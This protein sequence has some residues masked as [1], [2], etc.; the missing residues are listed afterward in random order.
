MAAFNY[1]QLVRLVPARTWQFY[2]EAR[3]IDLPVDHDWAMPFEP[4]VKGLVVALEDLEA[5]LA[6]TIYA[7]LRRVHTLANRRG[8]L[9]LRNAARPEAALHE[10]FARLTSD[11]E[12]AL[13][14]MLQWPDLFDTAEA[15][16]SVD[17]QIGVRGWKRLK[18]SPCDQ[19]FR[20]PEEVNAL[21]LALASAF[22]PRKGTRRACEIVTLDRHL[23]GGVQFGILIEDNPQRKPEFADDDRVRWRDI[24]PPESMDVVIYP[25][26]GV[27]D[28]LAPG[29]ERTRKI[30]LA[31]FAQH[32]FKRSIQPQTIAQ[33]MFFL[34]RLR[35]GFE[36]FDD[37]EVDLAAHRVEHIR[38]SQARVRSKLT[39]SCD[40]IIKP[41]G[42][43]E[44]ADVLACVQSQGLEQPLMRSAFNIVD[45][46]VTLYFLPVGTKKRGRAAHIELKQ[47]GISNLRDLT[48]DEAKL[49]EALLQ[50]WG[51]MERSVGM[52][53][54][55]DAQAPAEVPH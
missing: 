25:A 32:V 11:A 34:N 16:L 51:V 2:F 47:G 31:H 38:L 53:D 23:D 24:R 33:P 40:Y 15:F 36:L 19:I 13:W 17:L 43:K 9:A 48:E 30:L 22:T 27:I 37:S 46:T 26:N 42:E 28:I 1:H 5:D 55:E 3:K 39:P 20:G 54:I 52:A 21:R 45:A 12:R 49:A 18:I 44:A 50:A 35:E 8:M 4:L 10:D 7:E 29:G 14:T 6:R 41:P